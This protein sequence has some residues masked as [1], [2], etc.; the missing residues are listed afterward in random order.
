M[1]VASDLNGP[2]RHHRGVSDDVVS[3]DVVR[4]TQ[5][6]RYRQAFESHGGCSISRTCLSPQQRLHLI[7]VDGRTSL[8]MPARVAATFMAVDGIV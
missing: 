4:E 2:D 5:S 7:E 1:P 3:A 8:S 6:W